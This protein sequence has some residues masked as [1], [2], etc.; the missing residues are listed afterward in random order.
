MHQSNERDNYTRISGLL[1][2]NATPICRKLM[3]QHLKRINKSFPDFID[4]H[5]HDIFHFYSE[6]MCC[7]CK[8]NPS[9][10]SILKKKQIM[11]LFDTDD[12]SQRRRGHKHQRNKSLCCCFAKINIKVDNLDFTL[13]KFMLINFCEDEF[14]FCFLVSCQDSFEDFLDKQRHNLFHIWQSNC[15]CCLCRTGYVRPNANFID[16]HQFRKVFIKTQAVCSTP[17]HNFHSCIY[18]AEPGLTYKELKQRDL[19]LFY[20]L[21][22]FFCPLRKCIETLGDHRNVVLAHTVSAKISCDDFD[23]LWRGMVTCILEIAVAVDNKT[24]TE[25]R[26]NYQK[27]GPL[28]MNIS[29][30][31]QT[32][33]LAE[34][35][36][37]EVSKINTDLSKQR[38]I[39]SEMNT[40]QVKTYASLVFLCLCFIILQIIL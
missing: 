15:A 11:I 1:H 23:Y 36:Q 19:R 14:W 5:Q 22:N 8:D 16:K 24:E 7:L 29:A 12:K 26:I 9:G 18:K 34:I 13:L 20:S 3:E 21:T 10:K 4:D 37:K 6:K 31:W 32:E 35:N 40:S 25:I 33:L 27:T 38:D 2:D 30:Q 28:D 17:S 39:Q